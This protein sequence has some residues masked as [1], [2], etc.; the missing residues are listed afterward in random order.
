MK[1]SNKLLFGFATV[2]VLLVI[3]AAVGHW[4]VNRMNELLDEYALTEGKLV[5]YSQRL[6]SNVNE[7][8]RFEKDAFINIESTEKVAEYAKK[9]QETFD[10]SGKRIDA[11]NKLFAKMDS[12]HDSE[13][14]KQK[15]KDIKI[16]QEELAAYA[17]GFKSV[18]EQI[19]KGEVTTTSQANVAIGGYKEVIH[20]LEAQTL[21]NSDDIDKQ[22]EYGLKEADRLETNIQ[23]T[24]LGISGIALLLAVI[25]SLLILRSILKPL[26]A[27]LAMVTDIAQ[28]EGDLTRRLD[29]KAKDELGE[30][31]RMFNLFIEK[32][33][34]II[35]KMAITTSQVSAAANQLEA[36]AEHIATGAEQVAA[37]SGT[38][39]TAGEEM[40]ATSCD[41]AQNCQL[42]AEGAKLASE[43]A[44]SGARVV[45]ETIAVMNHIAERVQNSARA[46]ESLGSRSDQIGEIVGTIED[47][48][49]QTNLLAL[50]AAIEAARAGEQGRGFAVVADEVRALAERTTRAT[51]EIGEMIKAIQQETKGAVIAMD[52][53]VFE[54][55]NGGEKAASSGRALE[56]IQDQI[57]A[58]T[59]QIHQVATAAEEQ[60]ATT[61]E[62]SNNMQQITEVVSQT[63]R[64]AHEAASEATK[65][66]HI[67]NDLQHIVNQFKL[68]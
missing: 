50:N 45:D 63:A 9:W 51:R 56:H 37:Q 22:M 2:A 41:I 15:T 21:Q 34:T 30:I 5:E 24:I 49:D 14:A 54:V 20:K 10:R 39:A 62:I 7:L 60:T 13:F 57:N 43:A 19:R 11:M 27:M 44:V 64:G 8:R 25:L 23:R 46:V 31:S 48:A 40:S 29:G 35:S 61:S 32:L 33:H 68:A 67:S 66:S 4:G 58:V 6:R 18:L 16:F 28:G 59:A 55:G 17:T 65:L 42:A 12:D 47:I 3:V 53:G 36:T 52:E 1:I 26:S 38:V